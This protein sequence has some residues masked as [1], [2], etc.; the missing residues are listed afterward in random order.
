MKNTLFIVLPLTLLFLT[1]SAH[2]Q[3]KYLFYPKISIDAPGKHYSEMSLEGVSK[4]TT[5]GLTAGLE[6][7]SSP[8]VY[9]LSFGGGILYQFTRK[10]DTENYQG[11]RFATFYGIV[12]YRYATL[13]GVECSLVGNL[14]YDGNFGGTGSYTENY[15]VNGS[16]LAYTLLG[17]LY[18]AGGV[19]FDKDIFFFEAA[20][21]NFGGTASSTT[22]NYDAKIHYR[23]VS[24]SLG[25][26]I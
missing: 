11:F 2:A 26:L 8:I 21:K 18:Y 16:D 23:T 1:A 13:L 14:G 20:Y 17:G 9:N 10:L 12:K 25:V 22:Y 7:I 3:V 4:N 15:K 19:R 5:T 6:V 24:F